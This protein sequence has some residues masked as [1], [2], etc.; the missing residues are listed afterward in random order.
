[1]LFGYAR[2]STADQNPDHQIDALLRAGDTLKVTRLDQLSRS[3]LHLVTLGADLRE[4]GVGLHVI[5]PPVEAEQRTG[6]G[7]TS[8][9][10]TGLTSAALLEGGSPRVT[11][12]GASRVDGGGQD[13]AHAGEGC[14]LH[15][16]GRA[17]EAAD[18][19][20]R[21]SGVYGGG[22]TGRSVAKP[23][24]RSARALAE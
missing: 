18:P 23:S 4:R 19:V 3:V 10:T 20:E 24:S 13:D 1:V 11:S 22:R 8:V 21:K 2:V 5:G 16:A 9:D 7:V 14:G 6:L 12:A 17:D 15:R